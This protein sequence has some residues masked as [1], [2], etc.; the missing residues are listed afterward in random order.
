MAKIDVSKFAKG[1]IESPFDPRDYALSSVMPVVMRYPDVCPAPFDLTKKNQGQ[2]PSCVP[3]A[4]SLINQEKKL[5]QKVS[6][7]YDAEDFYKELKKIDGYPG[8]GTFFRVAMQYLKDEN[9]KLLGGD[10]ST[11]KIAKYALVDDMSFEGLKKAIFLYGS[12]LVGFRGSNEGWQSEFIRAPK[13]GETMWQ[14]AVAL[15]GYEKDYI[16][17]QNSWGK[18]WGNQG[19]FKI[20][21]NYLPF[22][23][24]AIIVDSPVE[25]QPIKTGWVAQKYLQMTGGTW[26]ATAKLNVRRDAGTSFE[27]IKTLVKGS[28]VLPTNTPTKTANGYVWN[29]IVV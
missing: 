18:E 4:A 23:A 8:P 5:L 7:E 6:Q 10:T 11:T 26:K 17:G 21:K 27:I 9:V 1:A 12:I 29:Q 16:V 15:V 14:H 13:P 25:P 2:N 3:N 28:V 24:W 19:Q 22:E 20:D